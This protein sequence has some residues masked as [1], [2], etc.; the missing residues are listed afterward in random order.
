MG[1]AGARLPAVPGE[2]EHRT[3]HRRRQ[4]HLR[5][6]LHA[7]RRTGRC[8]ITAHD[9]HTDEELWRRRTIPRPGEP[10]DETWGGLPG[11]ERRHVGTGMAPS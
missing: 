11:A 10:G 5:Q 7:R 9:P 8:V 3:E 4:R 1:D 2:A 6:K